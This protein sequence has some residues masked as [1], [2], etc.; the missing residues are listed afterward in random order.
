[1]SPHPGHKSTTL[2]TKTVLGSLFAGLLVFTIIPYAALLTGSFLPSDAVS[3]GI[4]RES[5][6]DA[7][8]SNYGAFF[9]D[10]GMQARKFWGFVFNTVG[11]GLCTAVTVTILAF[12][13]AY[14]YTRHRFTGRRLLR[15]L[16][17]SGYFLP[18]IVLAFPYMGILREL[19]LYSTFVGLYLANVAF[20]IPFGFWLMVGFFEGIPLEIDRV[21]GADGLSWWKV[22]FRIHPH[23]ARPGIASVTVFTFILSWNDVALALQLTE[24]KFRTLAVGVFDVIEKQ[25]ANEY[26]LISAGS[27]IISLAAVVLFGSTQILIDDRL[28]RESGEQQW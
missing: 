7:V 1:M 4:G 12:M 9:S 24:E 6:R 14:A 19:E 20:C 28:S 2:F 22:L 21:G 27:V 10:D 23:R 13:G 15:I 8:F 17:L 5:M 18:P 16:I 26:G 25:Q 11:I 3:Q